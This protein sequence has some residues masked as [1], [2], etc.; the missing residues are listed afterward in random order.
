MGERKKQI[1]RSNLL[2][3]TSLLGGLGDLATLAIGLLD[4]LDDTDGDGLTHVTDGET[5]ERRVLLEGLNAQGLGGDH[6]DDGGIARLDELGELLN[7]LT[8]TTIDL[9]E[10]LR[11]LASNMSGVAIQDGSV[12]VGDLTR[13]V[14]HNNLSV[15]GSS[16][17]G[18]V[19]LGVR[20]DV[21]A[22]NILDGDVLDVE[23]DV[24]TG[25]T[26]NEDFVMHLDGL[27]FSGD[28]GG[29]EGDNHTGLDDTGLNTTDGNC[30]DTTNLVDI[31]EGK[32]EGLLGRARWGLNGIN[33]LEKGLTLVAAVLAFLGPSLEPG[34]VG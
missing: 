15:E 20:A 3:G 31:L 11:E 16:L 13:V 27:D 24:V 6:L 8:G 12:S 34:H 25:N 26:L 10:N 9:L 21:T 23:S 33:G 7:G 22:A 30:S 28:V 14:Q 32:T 17:L 1:Q 18:G 5:S 29:S 4:G 19:V 2:L